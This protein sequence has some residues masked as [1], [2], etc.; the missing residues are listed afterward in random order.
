MY[1]TLEQIYL[2]HRQGLFSLA[3]SITQ[4]H[5]LAEDS[6][7]NAFTNLFRR[8]IPNG[9]PVAYVFKS[10]R[11]SAIDSIRAN[12]RR[13]QLN[14]SLFTDNEST[15]ATDS[16]HDTLVSQER[17]YLLQ[18]AIDELD[19]HYREAIVLKSFSGLTFEQVGMI[20]NTP[21]KT[22]ATRFR[23]ALQKREQKLKGQ[24]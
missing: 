1:E 22:V 3:L 23:R 10:V 7:H 19:D 18:Q 17:A 11:N 12:K 15:H 14:D 20:T 5:Q 6:V 8:P 9:D 4:S 2:D 24:L 13:S 16:A 21:A